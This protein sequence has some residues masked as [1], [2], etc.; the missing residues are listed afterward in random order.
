MTKADERKAAR[1][2]L[3]GELM[4]AFV[5]SMATLLT[6]WAGFQAA[7]WDGEQAAAYTEAG[8]A[9]VQ[10]GLLET[11]SGQTEAIDLFL[12]TEWLNAHAAGN[13]LL[14]NFYRERFRPEFARAFRAWMALDPL[15]NPNAPLAPFSMRD[16]VPSHARAAKEANAAADALFARGQKANDISDAFTRATVVLAMALFLGGIGQ[17]FRQYHLQLVLNLLAG[18]ACAFGLVMLT[19][20]PILT[21]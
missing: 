16:Y 8:S 13:T 18:A 6:S 12:F 11:E 3:V 4:A 17:T 1:R 20:L 10:A 14:E 5:L 7:L 19:S 9:R 21:L 2:H 15:D